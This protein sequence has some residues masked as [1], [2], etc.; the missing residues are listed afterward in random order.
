[1]GVPDAEK[2]GKT[3]SAETEQSGG[4]RGTP[5]DLTK[6]ADRIPTL[7]P[8]RHRPGTQGREVGGGRSMIHF[9]SSSKT[10]RV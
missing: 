2:I 8:H 5:V 4:Q 1:L 6:G 10:A 3:Q 9:N 7:W